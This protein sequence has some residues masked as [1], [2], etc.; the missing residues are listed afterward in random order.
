MRPFPIEEVRA[1][2]KGLNGEGAP[3]PDG[4]S[5]FFFEEF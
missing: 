3:G 1:A 4:L 5:V 2:V